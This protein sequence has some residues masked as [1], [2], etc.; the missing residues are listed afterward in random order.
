MLEATRG[1]EDNKE[2]ESAGEGEGTRSI[3]GT[4]TAEA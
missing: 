2:T 3:H 4:R 1:E